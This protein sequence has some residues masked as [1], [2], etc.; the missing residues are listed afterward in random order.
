MLTGLQPA[1]KKHL[2]LDIKFYRLSGIWMH[3]KSAPIPQ[4]YLALCHGT[5]N[6]QQCGKKLLETTCVLCL[7]KDRLIMGLFNTIRTFLVIIKCEWRVTLVYINSSLLLRCN[8]RTPNHQKT[9]STK[10]SSLL[11]GTCKAQFSLKLFQPY[12]WICFGGRPV[13]LPS[14]CCIL[15]SQAPRTPPFEDFMIG[16]T[17]FVDVRLLSSL[18]IAQRTP[19]FETFMIPAFR[20]VPV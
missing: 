2:N 17:S 4:L 12:L 14:V 6:P 7:R 3:T 18:P 11:I 13:L 20:V 1:R 10:S 15:L 16:R 19:P 9:K 8:S 5:F